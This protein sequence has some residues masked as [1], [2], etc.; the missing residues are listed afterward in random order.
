MSCT[1]HSNKLHKK[2]SVSKGKNNW[3]KYI[4]EALDIFKPPEKLTVSEWA[5]KFR[6]LSEK[7]SAQPGPWRTEKTPYL[8]GIMNAFN[9][10]EIEDITFV[11]GSQLDKTVAE[12]N[13]ISFAIDQDPGPMVI[14]Y[15]TDKLAKFTSE[16]RL[17]PMIQL[18]PALAGRYDKWASE[19]LEL[20]FDNMYIALLGV[21]SPSNLA[22]SQRRYSALGIDKY[23]ERVVGWVS[24]KAAFERQAYREAL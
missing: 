9:D 17:E 15:P 12:Q 22:S 24:P 19:K 3:P 14:V 18:S 7:D 10:E 23:V 21:N 1:T 20:Q 5:D 11:G 6:I 13:M 8:K 4:H 16:N 2:V